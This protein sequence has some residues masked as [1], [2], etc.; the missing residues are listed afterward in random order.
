M[1]QNEG[2]MI[3]LLDFVETGEERHRDE[4][5]DCFLAVADVD[6]VVSVFVSV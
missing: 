6:L 1:G 3:P 5:D 4:D 2:A